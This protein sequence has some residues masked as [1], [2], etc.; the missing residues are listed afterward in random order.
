MVTLAPLVHARGPDR[1]WARLR[2]AGHRGRTG[3]GRR[4]QPARFIDGLADTVDGLGSGRRPR[5]RWRSAA[6]RRRVRRAWL[7][8]SSSWR[9][10]RLLPNC[11]GHVRVAR[12]WGWWSPCAQIPGRPLVALRGVPAARP[13][14]LFASCV[15]PWLAMRSGWCRPPRWPRRGMGVRTGG[16]GLWPQRRRQRRCWPWCC[17]RAK[18]AGARRCAGCRRRT[19]HHRP[20][21][22]AGPLI[23]VTSPRRLLARRLRTR[24]A[25]AR[26]SDNPGRRCMKVLVTRSIRCGKSLYENLLADASAVTYVRTPGYGSQPRVGS[27]GVQPPSAG[28]GTGRPSRTSTSR[29]RSGRGRHADRLPGN[30]AFST[31]GACGAV[32]WR[33]R[34]D[35]ALMDYLHRTPGT[36]TQPTDVRGHQRGGLG[37]GVRVLGAAV[38]RRWGGSTIRVGGASDDVVTRWCR[39][40]PCTWAPAANYPPASR[41][42]AQSPD[43]DHRWGRICIAGG[44]V[45]QA[46]V[47]STHAARP[48]DRV[49]GH[50]GRPRRGGCSSSA[51]ISLPSAGGALTSIST[52]T[53]VGL[54]A[55]RQAQFAR[56]ALHPP[57]KSDAPAPGR[58]PGSRTFLAAP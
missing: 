1:W 26:W 4:H 20:A 6:R 52:R 17:G 55:S 33:H 13:D 31:A 18:V 37:A 54:P 34:F 51:W 24:V 53:V 43:S 16:W 49:R 40:V 14:G 2:S 21:R 36:A 29:R 57:P 27:A 23:N 3:D 45:G 30:V 46:N 19:G 35:D 12:N 22:D 28:P 41:L 11:S 38:R 56:Q 7:R 5:R 50:P 10:R 9:C 58:R 8:S 47:E 42:F 15:P 48:V 39:V 25:A 32:Q 44:D